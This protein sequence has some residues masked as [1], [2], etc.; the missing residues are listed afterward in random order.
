MAA[1][2]REARGPWRLQLAAVLVVALGLVVVLSPTGASAQLKD[3]GR[4]AFASDREDGDPEVYTMNPDGTG[5]TRLTFNV[6]TGGG[7]PLLDFWPSWSSDGAKIVYTSFRPSPTPGPPNGDVYI[8]NADGT[9]KIRI[10]T[11]P[12]GDLDPAFFPDG[13]KIVFVRELPS[14]NPGDAPADIWT[15][16]ADGTGETNLTPTP[17]RETEPAVSP[18]GTKIAFERGVQGT[19]SHDSGNHEIFVMNADGSGVTR[20]TN[21]PDRREQHPNF[22]PDGTRIVFDDNFHGEPGTNGFIYSM[23]LD[24]SDV[25]QLTSRTD[26]HGLPSYAPDGT[27]ILFTASEDIWMMDPDGSNQVRL[28]TTDSAFEIQAS[29]QP[30]APPPTPPPPT[31]PRLLLG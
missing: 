11:N 30:I 4:I 22:S 17:Q 21:T 9:G 31:P 8:M 3:N 6:N 12:A 20:L 29:W 25:T 5:V 27:K 19:E 7:F 18:D 24:G 2:R 10:T 14:P 16:N 1:W 13:S 23:N 28:T 15:I 26:R